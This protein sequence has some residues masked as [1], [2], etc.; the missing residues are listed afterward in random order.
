MDAETWYNL[1]GQKVLD[2]VITDLNAKGHK[3]LSILE[4]GDIV[5][6]NGK[7]KNLVDTLEN[8]PV[9][10]YWKE[11]LEILTD[12]DLTGTINQDQLVVAWK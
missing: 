9:K 11:L 7:K 3:R 12:N 8:F 5:T 2:N 6:G 4:N 10:S 1:I